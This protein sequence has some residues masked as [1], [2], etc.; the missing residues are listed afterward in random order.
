MVSGAG[1]FISRSVG[2][3]PERNSNGTA[4]RSLCMAKCV[5]AVWLEAGPALGR[6]VADESATAW[7][8][9]RRCPCLH[10]VAP[11]SLGMAADLALAA[12]CAMWATAAWSVA[13]PASSPKMP[14]VAPSASKLGAPQTVD[15]ESSVI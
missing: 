11:F 8:S 14:P 4:G 7:P 13:E 12:P 2:P 9:R 10:R 6:R 5:T 3:C 15:G 1:A